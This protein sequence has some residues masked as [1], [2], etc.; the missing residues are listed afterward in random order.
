MACGVTKNYVALHNEGESFGSLH[1]LI[2][3]AIDTV[4]PEVWSKIVKKTD[5][6]SADILNTETALEERVEAFRA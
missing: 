5:K 2:I 3:T 6:I 4:T 1:D